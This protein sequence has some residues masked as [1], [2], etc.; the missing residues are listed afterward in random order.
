[1]RGLVP[2]GLASLSDRL[3]N[4]VVRL[5]VTVLVAKFGGLRES[6]DLRS[7]GTRRRLRARC[8]PPAR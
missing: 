8:A 3:G 4:I 7:H 1:V 2:V 6:G 5:P